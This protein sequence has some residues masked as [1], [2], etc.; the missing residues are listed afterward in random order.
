VTLNEILYRAS[1]A[2]NPYSDAELMQ[3]ARGQNANARSY[4]IREA[5]LLKALG[6]DAG[7]TNDGSQGCLRSWKKPTSTGD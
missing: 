3:I 4:D 1:N 7:D 2:T 5:C 6:C